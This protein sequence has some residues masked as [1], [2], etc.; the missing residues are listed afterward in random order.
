MEM[1]FDA[2]YIINESDLTP[3]L[4]IQ[5]ANEIVVKNFLGKKIFFI[6]KFKAELFG[7]YYFGSFKFRIIFID[8]KNVYS[9]DS[10]NDIKEN[11]TVL[12]T[13]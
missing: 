4:T 9:V 6:N 1:I 11:L 12:K 13:T 2:F 5:K 3:A 10:Q 8:R 7:Y